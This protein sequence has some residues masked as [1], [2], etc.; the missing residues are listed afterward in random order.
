MLMVLVNWL[1]DFSAAAFLV[2]AYLIWLILR[3]QEAVGGGDLAALMLR[4]LRRL[5]WISFVAL[6]HF[7]VLRLLR[8]VVQPSA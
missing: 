3:K 5:L 6:M 7:G 2:G 4:H 8:R 1:H